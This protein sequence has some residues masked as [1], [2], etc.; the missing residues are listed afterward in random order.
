MSL[1]PDRDRRG[2]PLRAVI[3]NAI[4]AFALCSG[5][6]GIRF[7]MSGDWDRAL[8][9]IGFAAVLDGVDGRVARMLRGQS[10]FGAELDSLSD[11]VAFGVAP[12]IIVYLW[13][14]HFWVPYGWIFSLAYGVCMALRLARFN[15]RIDVEDQPHKSAGFLTGV[16]APAGAGMMLLP[17]MLWLVGNGRWAWLQDYRLVAAWSALSAFMIISSVA[18]FSLGSMRLRRTVRLEALVLIAILGAALVTVPWETLSLIVIVYLLM[19][20]YSM[21]R[22]ARIRRQ[23]AGASTL[24]PVPMPPAPMAEPEPMPAAPAPEPEPPAP[25]TRPSRR[26]GSPP[27]ETLL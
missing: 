25:D 15:A 8:M 18:T 22:Y 17:I 6:T 1:V 13:S 7:A 11:V 10:R 4:T 9:F 19:I 23:R 24:P 16:P 20:P 12:A 26:R 5:L 2:I 21:A 14:L 3:P 27:S